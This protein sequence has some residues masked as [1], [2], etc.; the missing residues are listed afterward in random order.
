MAPGRK[1]LAERSASPSG[2]DGK[3]I[4]FFVFCCECMHDGGENRRNTMHCTYDSSNNN[5]IIFMIPT[6]TYPL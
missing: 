3:S 1:R 2:R 5:I 6:L 4:S